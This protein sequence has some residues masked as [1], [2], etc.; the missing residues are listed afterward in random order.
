MISG[1]TGSCQDGIVQNTSWIVQLAKDLGEPMTFR[2]DCVPINI[3]TSSECYVASL[4]FVMTSLT[5]VGFGNISANTKTEQIFCVFVLLF[6]ALVYA[7]I[8]GNITTIIQQ[9]HTDTNR[10]H[11]AINSVSEFRYLLNGPFKMVLFIFF[12]IIHNLFNI[13]HYISY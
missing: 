13:S 1:V 6:G 3:P 12:L 9:L 11:D 7:T 8:F 5:S 10:Y 2:N 4:Y